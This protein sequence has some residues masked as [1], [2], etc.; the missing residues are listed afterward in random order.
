[1][2]DRIEKEIEF[3]EMFGEYRLSPPDVDM[4]DHW[5]VEV[6]A[7]VFE[8]KVSALGP[9]NNLWAAYGQCENITATKSSDNYKI[10]VKAQP[11]GKQSHSYR[12]VELQNVRGDKGWVFGT[13]DYIAFEYDEYWVMVPRTRLVDLCGSKLDTSPME[14]RDWSGNPQPYRLHQR[15]GRKDQVMMVPVVDLCWIGTIIQKPKQK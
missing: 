7:L 12:W 13:A 5:D 2:A 11:L 8:A 3:G 4:V 6:P 1:M 9:S 15:E 10:D 14:G